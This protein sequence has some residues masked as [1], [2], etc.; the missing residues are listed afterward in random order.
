MGDPEGTFGL[1]ERREQVV[2]QTLGIDAGE[3]TL[4]EAGHPMPVSIDGIGDDS[5]FGG[6]G[7]QV[8]R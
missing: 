8:D 1:V 2:V 5:E 6:D 7:G 4:D 3:I